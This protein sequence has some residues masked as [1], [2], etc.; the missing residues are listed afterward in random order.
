ML[1]VQ[2]GHG[3]KITISSIGVDFMSFPN[4]LA[5]WIGKIRAPFLRV[6]ASYVC[7]C[8]K[9]VVKVE[10]ENTGTFDMKSLFTTDGGDL[11]AEDIAWLRNEVSKQWKETIV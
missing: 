4:V 1:S 10:E 8:M 11:K 5:H 9:Y 3:D 6:S 7:Y 2:E